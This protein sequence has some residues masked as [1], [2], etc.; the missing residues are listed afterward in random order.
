MKETFKFKGD[1]VS[2]F[3]VNAPEAYAGG[4]E[5][6]AAAVRL[7]DLPV[8]WADAI[9]AAETAVGSNPEVSGWSSLG[10]NFEDFME[11]VK[12]QA[13]IIAGNIQSSASES[14]S[15]DGQSAED[16]RG[17]S[18]SPILDEAIVNGR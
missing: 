5:A 9:S 13:D 10:S 6:E 1:L 17:N 15:V 18:S 4:A 12:E 7:G 8:D 2:G 16:Y 11:E 14:S 3:G